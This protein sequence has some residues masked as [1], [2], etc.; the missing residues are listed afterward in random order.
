MKKKYISLFLALIM[1]VGLAVPGT[2]A[3]EETLYDRLINTTA[4]VS[5]FDYMQQAT[6]EEKAAMT[7]QEITGAYNH[8]N[9]NFVYQ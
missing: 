3:T 5:F 2:L 4:V 8:L 1:I 7:T 6:E 9:K